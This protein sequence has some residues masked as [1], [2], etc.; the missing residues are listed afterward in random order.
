MWDS[1]SSGL[2]SDSDMR[3][4][5]ETVAGKVAGVVNNALDSKSGGRRPVDDDGVTCPE[6]ACN[7]FAGELTVSVRRALNPCS[8][9][10]RPMDDPTPN[11]TPSNTVLTI[12]VDGG[13]GVGI[14][15]GGGGVGVGVFSGGKRA[16]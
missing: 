1:Q 9:I 2:F 12:D 10:L 14:G 11:P 16:V 6:G 5:R 3:E 13:G 7:C 4:G 8:T 15:F